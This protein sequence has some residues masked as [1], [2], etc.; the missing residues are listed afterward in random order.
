MKRNFQF[1]V[2]SFKQ[3]VIFVNKMTMR[4]CFFLLAPFFCLSAFSQAPCLLSHQSAIRDGQGL[5]L[6]NQDIVLRFT[7]RSG[8]IDGEI[9][10]QELHEVT[11]NSLGLVKVTLGSIV[12][13]ADITW[14]NGDKF[15]QVE[16]S[17]EG[18][19]LD[20]GTQQL[21]SVPYALFAKDVDVRVSDTGDSLFVGGN[22]VIVPGISAANEYLYPYSH[23]CGNDINCVYLSDSWE[24][25]F[26]NPNLDY[27]TI[28]DQEGNVYKTIVIG[29]QEWMA[30][31]LKTSVYR[32]GDSIIHG[33]SDYSVMTL[34]AGSWWHWYCDSNYECPFGKFYNWYACTDERGLCPSGWH[35][36]DTTDF[37]ELIAY[38]GNG[39]ALIS[40]SCQYQT[41]TNSSGFSG[42][43]GGN[44]GV[45]TSLL[46]DS[47]LTIMGASE[48]G[49]NAANLYAYGVGPGDVY[50]RTDLLKTEHYAVRCLKNRNEV[51]V[52]YGCM[53]VQACNYNPFANMSNGECSFPGCICSDDDDMTY[54]DVYNSDCNC[55]G[56]TPTPHVSSSC[57]AESVLSADHSYGQMEDQ[58]GNTYKTIVIGNQEWMAEN[59]KV[60]SYRNGESLESG[61][62]A[63]QWFNTSSG[64]WCY[65]DDNPI[66]ECPYGKLYNWYAIS[67]SRG[68]C[69]SGWRVPTT[70][71]WSLL[72]VNLE[73][74]IIS[75]LGFGLSYADLGGKLK[76]ANL[77][78][79][80]L[81]N[82]SGNNSSGFSALPGGARLPFLQ[83]GCND[84]FSQLGLEAFFWRMDSYYAFYNNFILSTYS[85]DLSSWSWIDTTVNTQ[86]S[87]AFSVRCIRQ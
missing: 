21:L 76:S 14:T 13:L 78:W 39:A 48:V 68:L 37:S 35:V 55:E 54:G 87:A 63:D 31:N 86:G 51:E 70:N 47:F 46:Y 1:S 3:K 41:A 19:F 38:V 52:V 20:L 74:N 42:L 18:G 77:T 81:P 71:D 27:G 17:S 34:E 65:Y 73:S 49:V 2:R 60:E 45:A 29:N 57:G 58:D 50:I 83:G 84:G 69:P 82:T 28:E 36:P 16:L 22:S 72:A 33:S 6:S 4:F 53:D 40:A 15:L 24:G 61:I 80:N 44:L 66:Y 23:S 11:T 9:D 62:S 7:L 67:D 12:S 10:W 25:S 56:L 75:N 5:V 32:N 8:Q 43:G 59:L 26:H 79:W 30:E 85:N 64:A